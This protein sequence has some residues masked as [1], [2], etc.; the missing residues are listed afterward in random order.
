MTFFD[1]KGSLLLRS[2]VGSIRSTRWQDYF[3][4]EIAPTNAA[5]VQVWTYQSSDHGTTHI[6]GLSL[7]KISEDNVPPVQVSQFS[8]INAPLATMDK[9]FE[10]VLS[11][12]F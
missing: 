3:V 8:L 7:R 9:T 10:Q 11:F 12:E 4:V 1:I 6:D 5:Y 2:D